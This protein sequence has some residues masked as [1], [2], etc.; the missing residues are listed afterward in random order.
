M[1]NISLPEEVQPFLQSQAIAAD[2][3][4]TSEY[5]YHL[6]VLEQERLAQ[7]T[8]IEALLMEGL[9]SGE[10]IEATDAWWEQKRSQLRPFRPSHNSLTGT[11]L[12]V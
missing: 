6:I 4:S 3:K 1:L 2:Y 8:R 9:K 5:V 7:Q 10:P 12:N 11:H